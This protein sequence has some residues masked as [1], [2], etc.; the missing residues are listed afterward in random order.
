ML[1]LASGVGLRNGEEVFILLVGGRV[2]DAP[3]LTSLF[4]EDDFVKGLFCS[5]ISTTVRTPLFKVDSGSL[6]GCET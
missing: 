4:E 6:C 1:I 2:P 5:E 3:A